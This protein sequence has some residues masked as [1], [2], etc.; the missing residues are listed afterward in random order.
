MGLIFFIL[1][2]KTLLENL[3][4]SFHD[5]IKVLQKEYNHLFDNLYLNYFKSKLFI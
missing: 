4:F 1:I 3:L 2:Y 5:N